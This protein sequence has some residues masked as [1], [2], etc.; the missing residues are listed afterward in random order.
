MWKPKL[1]QVKYYLDKKKMV[2]I[3][4]LN[5]L[6]WS[7]ITETHQLNAA[8]YAAVIK[9]LVITIIPTLKKMDFLR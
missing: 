1:W 3:E 8:N 5:E 7:I 9:I 6:Y 4:I 2:H